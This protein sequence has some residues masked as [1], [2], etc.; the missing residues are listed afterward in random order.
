MEYEELFKASLKKYGAKVTPARLL[1]LKI[2]LENDG[3]TNS[4]LADKVST[5]VDRSTVY[6]TIEL[7]STM[8]LIK[9]AWNGWKSVVEISDAYIAHHHHISCI[10][11]GL[12]KRLE[13]EQLEKAIARSVQDSDFNDLSH[14]LE[15]RGICS[16]CL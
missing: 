2:L 3:I 10:K 11:C 15:F 16:Q 14:I 1:I 12:V 6:R 7:F 4:A 13:S 9:R 5:S 8:G